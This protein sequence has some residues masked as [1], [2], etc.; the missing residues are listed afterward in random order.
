MLFLAATKQKLTQRNY[1]TL[2]S[3][4][5]VSLKNHHFCHPKLLGKKPKASLA[6]IV[7][8]VAESM[9]IYPL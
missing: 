8:F 5:L 9:I 6:F 3:L 4:L 2:H 7:R 1:V